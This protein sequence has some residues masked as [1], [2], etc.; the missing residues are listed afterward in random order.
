MRFRALSGKATLLILG[1]ALLPLAPARAAESPGPGP[2]PA[3]ARKLAEAEKLFTKKD[4]NKAAAELEEANQLAKGQC[5][6]CLLVLAQAEVALGDPERAVQAARAAVALGGTRP[7]AAAAYNQLGILLI[8][9]QAGEAQLAEA[10]ASLRRAAELGE[11]TAPINLAAL[12]LRREHPGKTLAL[13]RQ[14]LAAEPQGKS[15]E[16]AHILVCHARAVL[17]KGTPQGSLAEVAV[18]PRAMASGVEPPKVIYRDFPPLDA[19][20]A[21]GVVTLDSV[22]DE[23]GCVVEAKIPKPKET[24]LEERA[25]QAARFWVFQPARYQGKPVRVAYSI[26]VDTREPHHW[27]GRGPRPSPADPLHN[28][29]AFSFSPADRSQIRDTG[30]YPIPVPP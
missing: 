4:F 13:A 19:A 14:Y 7:F 20:V 17:A 11:G 27:S 2:D 8:Q 21:G 12:Q 30:T 28:P 23:E 9:P 5:G 6:A 25:L 29:Y 18:T 15:A 26:V 24:T 10:E 22:I 3:I 1:L 16:A